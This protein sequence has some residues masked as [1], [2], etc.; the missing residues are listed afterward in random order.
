L[1]NGVFV[2]RRRYSGH[3]NC[4]FEKITLMR[5]DMRL[6]SKCALVVK[7]TQNRAKYVWHVPCDTDG[8]RACDAIMDQIRNEPKTAEGQSK[9]LDE[10]TTTK[11]LGQQPDG[12]L[13]RLVRLRQNLAE[14]K[15]GLRD[16]GAATPSDSANQEL[17]HA[18]L[19]VETIAEA[20]LNKLNELAR[21][22]QRDP[23]TNL[24][25]RALM[26][27]RMENAIALARRHKSKFAVLFVD[28]DDFKQINDTMGHEVGDHVLQLVAHRLKVSVRDS[29]TVS[30]YG[31][32]ELLVLLQELS[33]ATDA[34]LIA[35][36]LLA[37]ISASAYAGEHR[38]HLS[39]S[40]G[41]AMYPDD[42]DD[43][44]TLIRCA[45]AAMYRS[46]RHA[47]GRF[48]FHAE[49]TSLAEVPSRPCRENV[50]EIARKTS[51]RIES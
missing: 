23:L 8:I 16:H 19:Q 51:P 42:G 33:Q 35:R 39:A 14:L 3:A 22:S 5:F 40:I 49:A 38:L 7:K 4:G 37:A 25:N 17:V 29:D 28:L 31:G 21:S 41:I 13:S 11:L 34:A 45:D 15:R 9:R 32:D 44:Q 26:Y 1:R 47:R 46:K 30:R 18:A 50:V 2:V 43:V 24:P 36:K 48:E 6:F 12:L 10:S 27:D 20:A